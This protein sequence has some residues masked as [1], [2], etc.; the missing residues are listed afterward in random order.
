MTPTRPLPR[1]L[2]GALVLLPALPYLWIVPHAGRLQ[3]NDYYGTL[4][5][6][7]D[8]DRFTRDP[9]RWLTVKSNEHT[10]AVAA[11]VYALNVAL[12]RGDNRALAAWSVLMMALTAAAL[13]RLLPEELARAGPA[14]AASAI[15]VGAMAFTPVAVHNVVMGFSGVMWLTANA[16]AVWAV[17]ALRRAT[18][19][20]AWR[21]VAVAGGLAL[22][23]SL[24]YSTGIA[25]WPALLL[26]AA[27]WRLPWRR[28]LPLVGLGL[29]DL[30]FEAATYTRPAELPAPSA[31]GGVGLIRYLA[32]YLGH[33]WGLHTVAAAAGL[34]GLALGLALAVPL[35]R[36]PA[37]RGALAPWFAV[38]GYALVNAVTTALARM[39]LGNARSSR[40]ATLAAL[41]WLAVL[42]AAAW[43]VARIGGRRSRRLAAAGLAGLC[44]ALVV[45]MTGRGRS[46]TRDYLA[47]AARQPLAGLALVHGIEDLETL[48]AVHTSPFTR[49]QLRVVRQMLR[50]LRHVPFERPPRVRYGERP[51]GAVAGG[52][53]G[54]AVRVVR[55]EPVGP[56]VLRLEGVVRGV[57][58]PV[59]LALVDRRGLVAGA[60]VA[61]P[62]PWPGAAGWPRGRAVR[63]AGYLAVA[64]ARGGVEI[65]LARD[66]GW[67]RAGPLSPGGGATP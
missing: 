56:A 62:P 61:M 60:G 67:C 34:A 32:A 9:L 17:V 35:W 5:K 33:L 52:C 30:A 8:G 21:W 4:A 24:T 49:E 63:W 51:G 20:G 15:V 31:G 54:V 29:L 44:V 41:Y 19:E 39:Q 58:G 11:A 26:A 38:G 46:L 66:D 43:L 12:T 42:V 45:A 50:R 10:V 22:V 48:R 27:A 7:V 6:V 36:R 14:G 25:A 13:W 23:A 53:A 1:W 3:Y 55:S 64:G 59:R 2:L 16:L 47:R 57:Q 28:V 40:Y 65:L 37:A 18:G